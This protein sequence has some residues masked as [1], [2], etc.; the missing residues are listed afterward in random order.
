M[1]PTTLDAYRLL[2]DGILAFAN[3]EQQGM[4]IDI[5]YCNRKMSFLTR[6]I[7]KLEQEFKE[8]KFFYHWKH[9]YGTKTNIGSDM[10]LAH[11]LY[12]IKKIVPVRTTDNGRGATDEESLTQLNIPEINARIQAEKLKKLRDVYLGAFVREQIGGTL[13]PFFNLHTVR[14]YRSSSD[15]PNYQNIPKRDKESMSIV[16]RAIFPRLG[17]QLAEIDYGGLEVK[18]AACYHRDPNMIRYMSDP[19]ADMHGD[20]TGQIF[21]I[22]NFDRK[23][24]DHKYL[25]DATKNGF[26]FPQFYGS[27]YANCIDTLC[28]WGKLPKGQWHAGQ[29]IAMPSMGEGKTLSDWMIAVGLSSS[30]KFE[31]HLKKIERD[32]W[33]RRF[34]V[35]QRWKD[36]WWQEYQRNGYFDLYTGFRCSGVMKRNDAINYPIQGSAFHC[37]LWSFIRLDQIQQEEGWNSRLIGQIHDAIIMDIAPEERDHVLRTVQRV[38]CEDLP[39]AWPWII[40]PLDVEIDVCDVDKPWSEK[41]PY[42]LEA[43]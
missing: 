19:G 35:Y 43:A 15:S 41:K 38:T 31:L 7:A 9:V 18:I 37:L 28:G 22:P 14:T 25:R 6:K 21:I 17:H 34:K 30:D 8:S 23:L 32:F 36:E 2:H 42:K 27:Y 33:Y 1:Q 13:H 26:V 11:I 5:D 24:P 10:Q 29:G 39:K 20:M 12:D 3:A 4:R 16:R 40:V